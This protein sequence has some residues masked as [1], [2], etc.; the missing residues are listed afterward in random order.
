MQRSTSPCNRPWLLALFFVALVPNNVAQSQPR[1]SETLNGIVVSG[2]CLT[3]VT[4][5]R[6]SV[7][8]GSTIVAKST[9]EASER[10]IK[11]H[12]ALK[13]RVVGLGLKNFISETAEYSVNQECSYDQGKR[14]CEGYRARLATRFETSEIARIGDIIAISSEL[15]SEEVSDL[16]TFAAPETVK[17]AREACL[18]VAIKNA[19]SKA[20]TLARG[21]G[22][23]LGKLRLIQE[24]AAPPSDRPIPIG[25]RGLE[26]AAMSADIASAGP[27]IDAK[28]LDL[29]VEITAQYGID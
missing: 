22:V 23:A 19:A 7:V 20:H 2:E 6:G 8:I 15:G 14:H 9:K 18:E 4:Q 12:E 3:K 11:A 27:S 29:K 1:D 26:V 16:T 5:D 10:A 13:A 25:R 24:S 21:A 28:P 17:S